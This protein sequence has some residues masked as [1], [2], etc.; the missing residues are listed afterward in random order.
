[1]PSELI[2]QTCLFHSQNHASLFTMLPS[3]Q[4][5]TKSRVLP[6]WQAPTRCG[7]CRPSPVTS[8]THSINSWPLQ[9][10]QSQRWLH[11]G[12]FLPTWPGELL[13]TYFQYSASE[14]HPLETRQLPSPNVIRSLRVA[15]YSPTHL[16]NTL[17][18]NY[19]SLP[20]MREQPCLNS[21]LRV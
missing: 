18:C 6:E 14:S 11:L 10:P 4:P 20:W 3:L 1:M 19:L 5:T 9:N 16:A 15:T 8:L 7:P 2:F 21:S 12:C 17:H 13:P